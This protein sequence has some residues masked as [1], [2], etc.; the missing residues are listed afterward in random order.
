MPFCKAPDG[1]ITGKMSYPVD[2]A[3]DKQGT[4]SHSGKRH[5]CFTAGMSGTYDNTGKITI[6]NRLER[7]NYRGKVSASLLF[8]KF[9]FLRPGEGGRAEALLLCKL[10]TGRAVF[11][12]FI[13][14]T[15]MSVPSQTSAEQLK[16]EKTALPSFPPYVFLCGVTVQFSPISLRRAIV[17]HTE[18]ED[19]LFER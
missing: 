12:I 18:T 17:S 4:M 6:H 1:G 14:A 15:T 11:P 5:G 8:I 19:A 13:L 10:I 7:R 9:F 2:V 3:G 16:G